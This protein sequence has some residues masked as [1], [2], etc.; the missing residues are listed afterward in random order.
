MPTEVIFEPGVI[1]DAIKKAD[2]VAPRKGAALDRA[3]GIVIDIDPSSDVPCVMRATNTELFYL[4]TL[5]VISATGD[6]VRWRLPSNLLSVVVTAF[7]ERGA[8]QV[9][10][11]SD[12]KDR[13][14]VIRSGRTVS[15][16]PVIDTETYPDWGVS[17]S[18]DL[19]SIANLGELMARVEWAASKAGP[20]PLDG[21]LVNGKF[22]V[23][24]DRYRVAR[25]PCEVSW[26]SGEEPVVIPAFG[27]SQ[28]IAGMG[29]VDVGMSGN[30]FVVQ[31]NDFMQFRTV[32]IAERFPS[33]IE[34]IFDVE[35]PESVRLNKNDLMSRINQTVA[36][37]GS[38]RDPIVEFYIGK[39]EF[40]VYLENTETGL[41]GDVIEIPGQA[42]HERVI[43]RFTPKYLIDTLNHAPVND[44]VLSYNPA[45]PKRAAKISCDGGYEVIVSPRA[46][47]K[48]K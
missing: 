32:T 36:F 31:P 5:S 27:I 2:R 30:L 28:S 21:V 25:V 48:S 4:E 42:L 29:A 16:I 1:S 26:A 33:A 20:T 38:N 44:I 14:V 7:P 43:I 17:S 35:L 13:R 6:A 34:K 10:F 41:F 8:R 37:A 3:A 18:D 47:V 45:N 23:A 46:E 15:K 40:A 39:E 19:A 12:D 24:T 22:L 11:E 9:K